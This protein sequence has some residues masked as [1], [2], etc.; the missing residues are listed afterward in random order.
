MSAMGNVGPTFGEAGPAENYAS[1]PLVAKW[2]II[3]CMLA[4]R[5]E[6]YTVLIL[7]VPQFWKN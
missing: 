3:F 1:M 2:I 5:L 7:L 4:G 6:I